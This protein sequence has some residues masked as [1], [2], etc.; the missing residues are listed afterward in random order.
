MA[1][2]GAPILPTALNTIMQ[3]MTTQQQNSV[4][5]LLAQNSEILEM[6]VTQIRQEPVGSN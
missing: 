2:D 6:L 3:A 5:S 4:N 1:I